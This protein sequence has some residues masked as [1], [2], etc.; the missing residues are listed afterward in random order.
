V[1]ELLNLIKEFSETH[2]GTDEVSK[3]AT[4]KI[5]QQVYG[6][7][8]NRGFSNIIISQETYY[9]N[10]IYHS[11]QTLNRM[12]NNY[13]QIKNA[14][15]KSDVEKLAPKLIRDIFRIFWFHLLVQEPELQYKFFKSG[16]KINPDLMNGIWEDDELDEI[17]VD[18]CYFPCIGMDLG[19]YASN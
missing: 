16:T 10:F 12:I 9:H 6:I 7:L 2:D 5:R 15:K 8:G 19:S 14:G 1:Q 18:L 3:V 17:C 11:S 13:H 4:I